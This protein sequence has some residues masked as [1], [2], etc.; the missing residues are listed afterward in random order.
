MERR[1]G[2]KGRVMEKWWDSMVMK[3][4]IARGRSPVWT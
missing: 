1:G 3:E 4:K 2:G